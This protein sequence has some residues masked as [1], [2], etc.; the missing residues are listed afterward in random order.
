[1]VFDISPFQFLHALAGHSSE[2]DALV[3]FLAEYFPFLVGGAL[4]VVLY[5]S[6]YPRLRQ[7]HIFATAVIAGVVARVGIVELL[8]SVMFRP[9]PFLALNFQPLVME[10]SSSFPSGHAAFFFSFA[11]AIYL[12]NKQWGKW[13]F[14]AAAVISIARIIAGVHYPSDIL[15]GS[16]IGIGMAYAVV[17]AVRYFEKS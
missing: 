3:I 14:A 13:F 16:A 1:M 7:I 4:V 15:A 8:H 17:R 6:G 12:Y 10:H 9:R 11:T 2:S 5:L